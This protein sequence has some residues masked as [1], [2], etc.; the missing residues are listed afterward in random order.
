MSQSSDFENVAK[1]TKTYEV[2]GKS[3]RSYIF[4]FFSDNSVCAAKKVAS[5]NRAAARL[6]FNIAT[7]NAIHDCGID[8]GG[9]TYQEGRALLKQLEG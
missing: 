3:G 6:D 9:A 8:I 4:F 2:I 7:K 1:T 5:F